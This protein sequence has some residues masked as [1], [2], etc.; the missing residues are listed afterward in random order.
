MVGRL[1]IQ[2]VHFALV[3]ML[4]AAAV[5]CTVQ[6]VPKEKD[7]G[8]PERDLQEAETNAAPTQPPSS[9]TPPST[10]QNDTP[11]PTPDAGAPETAPPDPG[12][13]Y[14]ANNE[15][16]TAFCAAKTLT[17]V[18]SPEGAKC[19]SGENIPQSAI[20]QKIDF[21]SCYPSC[22]AHLKPNPRSYGGECYGDDQKQ[23]GDG[24]DKTRGCFCK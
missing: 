16:C 4:G 7:I 11:K 18:A 8:L 23:D 14:Q 22:A 10:P 24:S 21:N 12:K 20:D 3:V 6:A 19:A 17:N 15:E 2:A 13:W 1:R 9:T 5:A